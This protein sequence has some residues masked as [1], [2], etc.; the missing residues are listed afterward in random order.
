[1][2][3]FVTINESY[4]FHATGHKSFSISK[5]MRFRDGDIFV[6]IF[7]SAILLNFK[8]LYLE[9]QSEVHSKFYIWGKYFQLIGILLLYL[10]KVFSVDRYSVKFG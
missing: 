6:S 3:K 5:S 4:T 1:M 7:Y 9:L 8:V 10:G 2:G